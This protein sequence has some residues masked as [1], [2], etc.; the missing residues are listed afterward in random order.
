M[1]FLHIRNRHGDDQN[2]EVTTKGGITVAY[3]VV[4]NGD[5]VHMATAK[6]S[7]RDNYCRKTGRTIAEGRFN[8]GKITVVALAQAN[9][10]P[11]EHILLALGD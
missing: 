1:R 4:N 5:E 2:Y 6:C 10:S 3:E 8:A 7:I 11:I 9:T